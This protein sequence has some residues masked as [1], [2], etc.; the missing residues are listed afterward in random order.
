[1]LCWSALWSPC[2]F[3]SLLYLTT[4]L[5]VFWQAAFMEGQSKISGSDKIHLL[6][7]VCL[8]VQQMGAVNKSSSNFWATQFSVNQ[9]ILLWF[10]PDHHIQIT[11]FPSGIFSSLKNN[12]W[13]LAWTS[14]LCLVQGTVLDA[15]LIEPSGPFLPQLQPLKPLL[16][17][18]QCKQLSP[19]P[20]ALLTCLC[21]PNL[22]HFLSCG[23]LTHAVL[24]TKIWFGRRGHFYCK[25][26]PRFLFW[27]QP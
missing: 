7:C 24:K 15:R 16:L 4:F 20:A 1:M 12:S 2:P 3:L 9:N 5:S 27:F 18:T 6:C 19:S 13:S 21:L 26:S 14:A 11:H 22:N 10:L 25:A 23:I 8:Y 17:W